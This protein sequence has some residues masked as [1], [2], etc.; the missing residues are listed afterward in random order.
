MLFSYCLFSQWP[1]FDQKSQKNPK[2]DLAGEFNIVMSGQF[3]TYHVSQT[4]MTPTPILLLLQLDLTHVEHCV[5]ED[6]VTLKSPKL[7]T[8][9][10]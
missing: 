8:L 9:K 4:P 10:H 3:R 1:R 7:L 2:S 5:H 6:V